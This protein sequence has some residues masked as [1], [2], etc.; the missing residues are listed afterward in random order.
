MDDD[1]GGIGCHWATGAWWL[2]HPDAL[3]PQC[4]WAVRVLVGVMLPYNPVCM[5]H[6]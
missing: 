5:V 3:V 4:V 1:S 6:V 2:A